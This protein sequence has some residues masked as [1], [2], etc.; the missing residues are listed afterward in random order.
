MAVAAILNFITINFWS[1]ECEIGYFFTEIWRFD[2]FLNGGRPP[3]WTLKICIF[4]P[5]ALIN[6][7]FCFLIQNFAENGQ[8]VD[9]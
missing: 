1:R 3:S 7:P 6:M 5:V 9:E 4:C 8:S 2:N